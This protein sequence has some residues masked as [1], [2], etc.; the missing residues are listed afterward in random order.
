MSG[1]HDGTWRTLVRFF[2]SCIIHVCLGRQ[3]CITSH[4]Y[5]VDVDTGL[6][7]PQDPWLRVFSVFSMVDPV[8]VVDYRF[9]LRGSTR[10]LRRHQSFAVG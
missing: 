8:G 3:K 5:M 7:I 4:E 1:V 6:I 10:F 9:I 2:C